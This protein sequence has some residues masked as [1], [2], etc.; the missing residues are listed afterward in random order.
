MQSDSI[1]KGF[2]RAPHRSLL[3]ATG[4]KDEDFNKPFIGV[5]NSYNNI[6]PGHVHLNKISQAVQEEIKKAGGVPFEFGVIGICDG[7]AMG[8]EGMKYSLASR[9][10]IAD[11]IEAMGKAH[12]FDAIVLIPN[13]DKIIPGMIMGACRL[14]L[15]TIV[16]SGG[17]MLTGEYEGR[18]LDLNSVFEAIG[19]Y[20]AKK[21]DKD[22][23]YEIE[24][25][26]CPGP[27][28]CSGMFTAN[29]MNC[30]SEALGLGLPGNGTI[31][32]VFPERVELA[33]N[34]GRQILELAKNNLKIRDILNKSAFEN[35]LAVD[36]ALGCSTNSA[37][38]LPA[39]A[40]EA[41]VKITLELINKISAKVAHLCNLAP[42]GPDHLQDL[43]AA[44]GIMAVMNELDKKKFIKREL[45]TVTGKTIYEN[46][47]NNP[48][49]NYK[50]IAPID[51]PHHTVGGLAAL[52]GNIAPAGSIVKQSAVAP[53]MLV[54]K[55]PARVFDSEDAAYEAIIGGKI[56]KG[57]VIV[58]RYEGPKGG[59]GMREMLL[60]T[61]SI[62]GMGLDK[63]VALLTDGR[64]S[65]ASRGSSIGHISPEAMAGGPIAL[66]EEGD[67]IA[68]DIPQKKLNVLVSAKELARRRKK[69]KQPKMKI[70]SG[71]MARYAKLVTSADQG[72]V[73]I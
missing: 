69:W 60:P 28:S 6:I 29:S 9:E 25:R 18:T 10:L 2:T 67:I 21:I 64:F 52:F 44:G 62:A 40:Y 49:K 71:Y 32:A 56:K 33:R 41:G 39:I 59:P 13:C 50:V 43:H 22:Q 3:R 4:L 42:A 51:Q 46:Y 55:G 30:L 57:D 61:S 70:T 31:P 23:L 38:H 24:C 15:P 19:E 5:A 26:A 45:P 66:I 34:A 47:K 16:I 58:I 53:E 36:M 72:A 14:N 35:A 65:G 17:P 73:L 68:I 63:D 11:S 27:G 1:K 48:V 54:H 20:K 37:L 12:C 8:H 7:I